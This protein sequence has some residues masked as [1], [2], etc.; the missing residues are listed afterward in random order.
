MTS[1]NGNRVNRQIPDP[2][3]IACP[4]CAC[5]D[6]RMEGASGFREHL[7]AP[8]GFYAFR[9]QNC[10]RRFLHK[11][12]SLASIAYAK[13]PRCFRMDLSAWDP[14]RYYKGFWEQLILTL[15]ASCWRCEPCRV[16]FLSFRPRRDC[17]A[18]PVPC[19]TAPQDTSRQP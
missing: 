9:C 17:Y 10:Y 3:Q 11:P 15:G 13:C 18:K 19:A 2:F 14:K 5:A 1:V 7:I 4:H 16:N 8:F 12:L 6:T